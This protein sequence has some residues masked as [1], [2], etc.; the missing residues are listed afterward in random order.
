MKFEDRTARISHFLTNESD[1][2]LRFYK[3]PDHLADD[4]ARIRL[5]DTV[6]QINEIIPSNFT[7]EKMLKFLDLLRPALQRRH[8]SEGWP[9]IKVFVA[10]ARDALKDMGKIKSPE[11]DVERAAVGRLIEWYHKFGDCMPQCGR[12]SR[13]REMIERGV[14]TPKEARHGGFPMD[15]ELTKQAMSS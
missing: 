14:L 13:T 3:R 6:Q 1:G 7:E 4:K 8:G 5:S 2:L 9:S 15:A 10:S 12:E 11:T